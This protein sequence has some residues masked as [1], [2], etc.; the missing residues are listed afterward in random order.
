MSAAARCCCRPCGSIPTRQ[1]WNRRGFGACDRAAGFFLLLASSCHCLSTSVGSHAL[2][3]AP[4]QVTARPATARWGALAAHTLE[5]PRVARTP[6]APN[7]PMASSRARRETA[8]ASHAAA[9]WPGTRRPPRPRFCHSLG[10]WTT[11]RTQR[12]PVRY[13]FL[14]RRAVS[15][16]STELVGHNVPRRQ[17]CNAAG[18]YAPEAYTRLQGGNVPCLPCPAG[19]EDHDSDPATAYLALDTFTDVSAHFP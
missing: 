12:H 9:P 14:L 11:T 6:R 5:L 16:L 17:E 7:A 1:N 2:R 8:H 13:L 4:A 15:G 3:R 19:K 10:R 18:R